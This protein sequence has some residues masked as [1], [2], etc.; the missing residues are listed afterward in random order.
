MNRGRPSAFLFEHS[1]QQGPLLRASCVSEIL[2]SLITVRG[3]RIALLPATKTRY[4]QLQCR[5]KEKEERK[6]SPVA[7][8]MPKRGEGSGESPR[9]AVLREGLEMNW[10]VVGAGFPRKLLPNTWQETCRRPFPQDI[11]PGDDFFVVGRKTKMT[12]MNSPDKSPCSAH[13]GND[14]KRSPPS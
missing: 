13:P 9:S 4:Y 3:G 12:P 8:F 1:P 5:G 2:S 14:S 11:S 7:Y 6:R 10:G